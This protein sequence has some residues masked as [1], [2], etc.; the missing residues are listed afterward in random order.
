MNL[1]KTHIINFVSVVFAATFLFTTMLSFLE[2]KPERH[3]GCCVT[4]CFCSEMT[5]TT[6]DCGSSHVILLIP[7]VNLDEI[8]SDSQIF[9]NQIFTSL[10]LKDYSKNIT[11]NSTKIFNPPPFF[12]LNAPLLI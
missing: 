4:E 6:I 9:I 2:F 11:L 8:G 5:E 10:E 12:T 1:E 7:I 3:Q